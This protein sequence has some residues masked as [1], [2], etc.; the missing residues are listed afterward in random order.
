MDATNT[1]EMRGDRAWTPATRVA[2]RVAFVY[3][4]LFFVGAMLDSGRGPRKL[5]AVLSA[6]PVR[7]FGHTVLRLGGSPNDGG[8]PWAIAQQTVAVLVA[9]MIAAAWSLMSRRVEYR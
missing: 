4:G 9:L 6:P 8:A 7:W 5:L 2:F 1:A 3:F